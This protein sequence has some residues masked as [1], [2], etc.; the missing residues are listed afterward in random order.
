MRLYTC[1][2]VHFSYDL[3]SLIVYVVP[4]CILKVQAVTI[5]MIIVT[6]GSSLHH[7]ISNSLILAAAIILIRILII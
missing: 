3:A 2:E 7:G 6:E 5:I 4:C 1:Q